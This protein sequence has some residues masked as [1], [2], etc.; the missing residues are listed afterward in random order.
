MKEK[1]ESEHANLDP[2]SCFLSSSLLL[3][4]SLADMHLPQQVE[5]MS[6]RFG[7][8]IFVVLH[9][10][11]FEYAAEGDSSTIPPPPLVEGASTSIVVE[12]MQ[13]GGKWKWRGGSAHELNGREGGTMWIS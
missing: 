1:N 12:R 4:V 5:N 11:H 10:G 7:I 2:P 13:L 6:L 3:I 8:I 9:T